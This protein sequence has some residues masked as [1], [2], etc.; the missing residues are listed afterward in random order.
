VKMR[1]GSLEHR[2]LLCWTFLDTHTAFEPESLA[3]PKLEPKHIALLRSFPFWAFALSLEQEA[4]RMITV[5]AETID[6][7]LVRNSL[8]DVFIMPPTIDELE[9]RLRK[10]GTET[11]AQVQSRLATG[12]EESKLWRL[13]KYTI[14][15]S[16]MEEDLTKFRAIMRAERYLSQRLELQP[17][18]AEPV[19]GKTGG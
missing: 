10:R 16:S 3:W 18:T 13:Y 1:V 19:R 7:P 8:V 5:F 15:S 11:E 14:L 2:D 4:G 12:R 9:K 6:D 17:G